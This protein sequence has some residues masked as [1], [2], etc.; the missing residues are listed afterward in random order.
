[1]NAFRAV[2]NN[3]LHA[4]LALTAVC[5]L[6]L[7][8][9]AF[10]AS[11]YAESSR[12]RSGD[13]VKVMVPDDG[14]YV[15]TDEDAHRWGFR[16]VANLRVFGYGGHM[17]PE[18]LLE[19]IPDD[20]PQLPVM[21]TEGALVFYGAGPS[22]WLARP[23]SD[24][25]FI[26]Q[27]HAYSTAGYYFVTEDATIEDLLVPATEVE[28]AVIEPATTA[29]ARVH[30]EN[31]LVN[32]GM[33]GRNLLGEDISARPATVTF[34]L[35][36]HVAG[37]PVTVLT[38]VAT[39]SSTTR[40]SLSFTANDSRLPTQGDE[41]VPIITDPNH[42]HYYATSY[43][44]KV[45]VGTENSLKWTVT[46]A[47][48]PNIKIARLDYVTVNYERSLA[49]TGDTPLSFADEKATTGKPYRLTSS[50]A[51]RVWDV[52][53]TG[54]PID[55][56]E[57]ESEGATTFV[58]PAAGAREYIAFN[59]DAT[60][61]L[62]HPVQVAVIANQDLHAAETPDMIILAPIEYLEQAQRIATVHEQRDTMRVMVLSHSLVFNEFSSGTP[63]VM[64][65]RMLCKM[66]YDRGTDEQG[67]SLRYLLLMGGATYDNRLLTDKLKGDTTPR[68][69][70]WQS[71]E[72]SYENTSYCTDDCLGVLADNSGPEFHCFIMDIAVGRMPARSLADLRV[73]V[74][75][76]V[77]YMTEPDY[78][79]WK[80]NFIYLADDEDTG[81]HM[82]QSELFIER[83]RD[84]GGSDMVN[85]HVYID[86]F[87]AVSSG[88]GR[89]YPAAR[90]AFYN[91]LNE[92]QLMWF[93]IGHASPNGMTGNAMVQRSDF[94][95]MFYYSHLPV[96]YAATCEIARFDSDVISGG[97]LL[98]NNPNGGV[99]AMITTPR[100]AF[101]NNNGVLTGSLGR[102][103]MLREADGRVR[104]LG[105]VLRTTKNAVKG[106]SNNSRYFLYGDPAMRLAVPSGKVVI[107][108]INGNEVSETDKPVFKARQ[109]ITMSGHVSDYGGNL[110]SNFNGEV[111]ATLFDS[112]QSVITNGYGDGKEFVYLDR[113]NKL[114]VV[115]AVVTAGTFT[116][117]MTVP[118]EIEATYDNY[119][120]S[121]INLYAHD[122]TAGIE[123]QGSNTDFYI[124]GYDDTVSGDD[125]P[126]IINYM[127]L[128]NTSD[129]VD[130]NAVNS[131]PLFLARVSDNSGINISQ[132]GIGHNM[133]ITVDETTT[134]GD[135]SSYYTPDV[136]R[137]GEGG[138]G[139]ISY[140]LGDLSEGNHTLRL[141]V[142]D[143][144][145]NSSERTIQFA[146][147]SGMRPEVVDV[148]A[149]GNPAVNETRFYITHN[150][151]DAVATVRVEVYDINGRM[152]WTDVQSGR[153]SD[154][155]SA[156]VVWDLHDT[157][158]RRVPRGIYVYRA[159]LSI[160]G[161]REV[162]KARRLA[163]TGE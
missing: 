57:S 128:N 162:S 29:T 87:P 143:V 41:S 64:A 130:G 24:V 1:M 132:A 34:D 160:D 52:T 147:K 30:H 86:A 152:V 11:H 59:P 79:V 115:K 104:P 25:P 12:L 122:S 90:E 3:I 55:V 101:V 107:D 123:A 51:T 17:L 139:L 155:T 33:T 69:L 32:P 120:P 5:S 71:E 76:A 27:Q 148:Y 97:E 142:W 111:V 109:T 114:S 158:G 45:D 145:N 156:P 163:V 10:D 88:T 131:S 80:N 54:K 136:T 133:S 134:Y 39:G 141:R 49:L 7:N 92:G 116:L 78:G 159:S 6:T 105:E 118:S 19:T 113:P 149:V 124:Y 28:A 102:N 16:S 9:A 106:D 36:G 40:G 81:I 2:Y 61:S 150:R 60:A 91:G 67:H 73:M 35:S 47:T 14:M 157:G 58:A 66:F 119:S 18:Q 22:A 126:P 75:K 117:Q 23:E 153:S 42:R 82:H 72:S 20:L 46:Y 77:N 146:V 161:S 37:T 125:V 4:T 138:A 8:V 95:T 50:R 83:M 127:G 110:L 121:L 13:W 44:R 62:P 63:D 108:R 96:L 68:L 70:L 89:V 65:Y 74:D 15:I 144:F 99:A 94:N 135:V 48:V 56:T 154:F 129:F 43:V 38:A 98:Y 53:V 137:E 93:F 140:Q 84:H 85:N 151:P 31:E 112:E 103:L 100:L 21:R 26:K